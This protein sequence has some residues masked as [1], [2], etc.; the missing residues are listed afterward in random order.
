MTKKLLIITTNYSGCDCGAPECNCIKETGVYLEEFAVPFLVFEKSGFDITTASPNGMLSPV[1]E[2]SMSCSNPDE[3][4]KC[5]KILRNTKRLSQVDYKGFDGV[6][7]PGGHGPMFDLAEN[8]EVAKVVEH[9]FN[10]GKL[11]SAIC[12]GPAALV[13]AKREDGKSMLEGKRITAFTNEEE[14]IGKLQELVPFMLETKLRELG[15]DF[16]AEK[17]WAEHVEVDR[18]FITGQ[19]QKS[20]LLLAE[21]IINWFD[22]NKS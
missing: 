20:A 19:N 8:E 6:Y 22:E 11:I 10:E 15:A 16:I 5:I 13:N 2:K 17:P 1:D 3:W 14:E 4:D 18:N 7:F 21:K 9:F 12:H